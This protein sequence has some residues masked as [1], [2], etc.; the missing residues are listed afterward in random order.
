VTKCRVADFDDFCRAYAGVELYALPAVTVLSCERAIVAQTPDLVM[1]FAAN[2]IGSVDNALNCER[3]RSGLW[4]DR[5][6]DF[7]LA[8][9]T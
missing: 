2:S 7:R 4:V 3:L 1:A 6:A 5:R 8:R 9:K